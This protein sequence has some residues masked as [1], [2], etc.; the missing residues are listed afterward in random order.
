MK[1]RF[2]W[3]TVVL[4]LGALPFGA[5]SPAWAD[6][7]GEIATLREQIR[8][9]DQKLRVL[10]RNQQLRDEA[11]TAAAATTP[12]ITINDR[13]DTFASADGANSIRVRGLVQMDARF[14]GADGGIANNAFVLR[15]ARL[16]T[17]G[18]FAKNFGFQLLSEF[19]GSS[20]SILDANLTV[21]INR[22]LQF[23]FGKF[24]SPVGYEIIQSDS[25]IFFNERSIVTNLVP[26]R[27]VGIQASGDVFGGTLSY[28]LG[29]FNGLADGGS[30]TNTD[31]DNGKELVARVFATPFRNAAGSPVQGLSFGIS[32]S[33]AR[34][35][36]AAGR[37]SGYRT[38]GQQTF[39]SYNPAVIADGENWR[40]SPQLDYR[41]GAFGFIGE[42]ARSTVNVRPTATGSRTELTNRAWQ[43]TAGYVLTG[44]DSAFAGV[45]PRTNFDWSAGTWG[46]LELLVRYSDLRI[47]DAAFP[48]FAAA[49]SNADEA[50]GLGLGFNW[51]LGKSV[52]FKFNYHQT[53]FGLNA[54]A[55]AVPAALLLRQDEKAFIS[56]FQV[57]F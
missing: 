31:F 51:Y 19:G 8:L 34:A 39:F 26:N 28:Q 11:A 21:G 57:A 24:K 33:T 48:L 5:V 10:E 54:L 7:A 23:K 43:A 4:T 1:T 49:A 12:K 6:D 20:V 17:E 32:G 2:S 16:I 42:Y 3:L 25:Y 13:G 38:D 41:H 29:V 14:F 30:S 50:K 22:A 45:M 18:Q 27:D 55:P 52:V 36:T 47:D 37:S 35:K 53:Q 9:L 44:E 15:R 46:A 40:V 56:R